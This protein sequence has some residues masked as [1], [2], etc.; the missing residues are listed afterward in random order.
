LT[1]WINSRRNRMASAKNSDLVSGL[2]PHI[3]YDI[4]LS[5]RRPLPRAGEDRHTVL[6]YRG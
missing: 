1:A 6:S 3:L 2:D 4:G 5:D